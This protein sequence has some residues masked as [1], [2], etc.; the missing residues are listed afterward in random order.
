M[1][2]VR[3]A[4]SMTPNKSKGREL[5]VKHC[6]DCHGASGSGDGIFAA[7]LNPKPK[8][9]LTRNFAKNVTP[10][11][12]FNYTVYGLPTGVMKS[13]SEIL[14]YYDIWC[15]SYYV[16]G[17]PF[18]QPNQSNLSKLN[19]SKSSKDLTL[20][21]LASLDL[22]QLKEAGACSTVSEE[23]YIRTVLPYLESKSRR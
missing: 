23:R 3:L 16:S 10:H 7:R 20:K 13:L 15:L 8:S 12:I 2:V 1:F 14:D 17:L 21:D 5:Y 6:A 19:S 18:D 4:P 22:H 11:M 9:L